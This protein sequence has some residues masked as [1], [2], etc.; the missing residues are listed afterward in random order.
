MRTVLL[1]FFICCATA[2]TAQAQFQTTYSYQGDEAGNCLLPLGSNIV[3]GGQSDDGTTNYAFVVYINGLG[4]TLWTRHIGAPFTNCWGMAPA[5]SGNFAIAGGGLAGMT[6]TGSLSWAK[7][8]NG[9]FRGVCRH[10]SGFYAAGNDSTGAL[11]L[12][13]TDFNGDTAWTRT[14][15]NPAHPVYKA[16][17]LNAGQQ[18]LVAANS[19]S[20]I[21]LLNIDYT[22]TL[23]WNKCYRLPDALSQASVNVNG[24]YTS[25]NG[26]VRLVGSYQ[27]T[28]N[29]LSGFLLCV[30]NGGHVIRMRT[31]KDLSGNTNT[32]LTGVSEDLQSQ[33]LLLSGSG[34]SFFNGAHCMYLLKTDVNGD[35]AWTRGYRIGDDFGA[36][37]ARLNNTNIALIGT[38]TSQG[39]MYVVETDASGDSYCNMEYFSRAVLPD[40]AFVDSLVFT[41]GYSPLCIAVSP[42]VFS[43][44]TQTVICN[45]V[46]IPEKNEAGSIRVFPNP[47]SGTI[48]LRRENAAASAT[49][50]VLDLH[51]K[52]VAGQEQRVESGERETQLEFTVSPGIYLLKIVSEKENEIVKLV[53]Q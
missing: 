34:E 23:L 50:S 52:L 5:A 43:G 26:L 19:D 17:T 32:F 48:T 21:V 35:T 20:G 28:Q 25:G 29:R 42:L 53:V 9:A 11:L 6:N 10:G 14:Y 4:D 30:D 12:W 40:T 31:Y 2:V 44:C 1:S 46:G 13:K 47:S 41:T 27:D 45:S 15:S 37:H 33:T 8:G 18:P 51:G 16:M 36:A 22:G 7:Q 39:N 3:A 49:V 38:N 24:I